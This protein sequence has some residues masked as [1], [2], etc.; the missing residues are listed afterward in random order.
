FYVNSGTFPAAPMTRGG[1]RFT[2]TRH[3]SEQQIDSL[4]QAMAYY[5]PSV[6]EEERIAPETI[7]QS[8]EGQVNLGEFLNQASELRPKPQ[9][10]LRLHIEESIDKLC[11]KEW[12]CMFGRS[13]PV[14]V[15]YLGL[16][17]RV[18]ARA[19]A[20][21]LED[22]WEFRYL[23]VRDE[24]DNLVLAAPMTKVLM[25]DD[26]FAPE[27]VSQEV[28]ALRRRD[29]YWLTSTILLSGTPCGEG[30]SLFINRSHPQWPQ[31]LAL[32]SEEVRRY[33]E[34]VGA[35]QILL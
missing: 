12:N 9:K 4:V 25:K 10:T 14:S 1:V 3:H 34:R 21:K 17:E 26:M 32:Y 15:E 35:S 18:F 8:F 5:Y 33:G 6:L 24:A 28:E 22:Q 20:Q 30:E 31:A 16:L 29:P 19:D 7:A 2:L 27:E 23:T 11:A 13:G